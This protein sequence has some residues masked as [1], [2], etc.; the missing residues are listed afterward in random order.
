M[1][2]LLLLPTFIVLIF[3]LII[4]QLKK[5]ENKYSKYIS[6]RNII[7]LLIFWTIIGFFTHD[8]FNDSCGCLEFDRNFASLDYIIYSV[9]SLLLLSLSLISKNKLRLGFIFIETFYWLFKL[10]YLKSG[11]IGGLGIPIFKIFDFIGLS[12]RLWIIILIIKIQCEFYLIPVISGLMIYIK[13]AFCPCQKNLLYEDFI[14]PY[15]I[16]RLFVKINGEWHGEYKTPDIGIKSGSND[17]KNVTELLQNNNRIE[18]RDTLVQPKL[19]KVNLIFN[20]TILVVNKLTENFKGMYTLKNIHPE[21]GYLHYLPTNYSQ[22]N[23]SNSDNDTIWGIDLHILNITDYQI[24]CEI[25][26][27]YQIEM[28]RINSR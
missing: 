4:K 10:Y 20:D 16:E 8:D 21:K 7:L 2:E 23:Y 26:Y 27:R 14:K 28:H 24:K 11:Y 19:L 9:I 5:R 1:L 18:S 12:L 25:N 17:K 13:L 15:Y 3:L 6:P 22:K